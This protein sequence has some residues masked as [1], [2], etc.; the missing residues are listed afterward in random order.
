MPLAVLLGAGPPAWAEA[1]G[2]AALLAPPDVTL[3]GPRDEAE[4]RGLVARCPT[5][6]RG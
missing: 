2:P 5:T 6:S 4:A 3:L 1:A